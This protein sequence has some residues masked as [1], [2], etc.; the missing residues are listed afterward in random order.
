MGL[1]CFIFNHIYSN[2]SQIKDTEM[3]DTLQF[4]FFNPII[5][6]QPETRGVLVID[7]RL[8]HIAG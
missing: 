7:I 4:H 6:T 2:N 5:S 1:F 8:V 3:K